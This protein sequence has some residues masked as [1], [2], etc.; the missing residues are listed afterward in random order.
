MAG[1]GFIY[2]TRRK[3]QVI[4]LR[5]LGPKLLNKIYSKILLG[6]IPNINNPRTFNEK[7]QY[8]KINKYN[9]DLEIAEFT[10]K[11]VVRKK[12][13]ELGLENMLP[14]LYGVW[15]RPEEIEWDQLPEKF[16][17]KCNHGCAYNI[18][19]DNKSSFD[20]DVAKKKLNKWIKEDFGLFNIEP[21]YSN[22]KRKIICEEHLGNKLI[23]YKFYC[24]NG[25]PQFLY[26]SEDLI[27]D[28]IAKMAYYDLDWNKIP[29]VR[30][31]YDDIGELKKPAT[32][33]KMKQVSKELSKR[34][35]FVRVDLYSIR[36]RI[37]FSEMTFTPSAGMMPIKPIEYDEKWGD[38]LEI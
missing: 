28:S 36:D 19:C 25:E 3:G 23:D 11:Y 38:L 12:I 15:D 5:I 6:Y 33:D 20:I 13:A 24:F 22:I 8:L 29:L 7:I 26:V 35:P 2:E 32:F 10:D 37:I 4:A 30:D 14:Q 17:L 31:D 1:S 34:F 27:H 9:N 21:H 18:I 16:V